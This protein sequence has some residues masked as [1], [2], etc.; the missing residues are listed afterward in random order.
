MVLLFYNI[1]EPEPSEWT[2]NI[3]LCAQSKHNK[4]VGLVNAVYNRQDL[5]V[6]Y[7]VTR[8]FFRIQYG[9]NP[10]YTHVFNDCYYYS[11]P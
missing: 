7:P 2:S 6:P 10:F 1:T 11:N 9:H 4:L 3:R 5:V 8:V